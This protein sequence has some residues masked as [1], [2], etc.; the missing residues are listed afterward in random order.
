MRDF[1]ESIQL[2]LSIMGVIFNFYLSLL[3][4]S[5]EKIKI[6]Y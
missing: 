6:I 2:L 3:I 4:K 5:R 1:T